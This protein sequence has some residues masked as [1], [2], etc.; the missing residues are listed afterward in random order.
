MEVFKEDY[1]LGN[2]LLPIKI[3]KTVLPGECCNIRPHWHDFMEI[4][5]FLEG[6]AVVQINREYY[7]VKTGQIVLL[8]ALDIHSV[9]GTAE[10][11]VLQF[12]PQLTADFYIDFIKAFPKSD[13]DKVLIQSNNNNRHIAM[14]ANHLQE[15]ADIYVEKL[16]GFEISIRGSIYKIISAIL[17]YSQEK[18]FGL[19]EYQGQ[20]QTLERLD[21]LLKYVDAHYHENITIHDAAR[22]LSFSPNYF[23]RFFKR[24]MGKTFLEYLNMFR[25]SKAEGLISTT[26]RSITDIA[27]SSG[28]SSVSYFNRI[29]KRYKGFCPSANRKLLDKIVQH[30]V[31]K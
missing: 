16:P 12:E 5:Y 1:H 9:S 25:C 28:F 20:K 19:S 21:V 8:N 15:I 10:Y 13:P 6:S 26:D 14:I 7:D 17:A 22:R 27:L 23:C 31:K 24:V 3:F 11:L 18:N 2:K 30:Q 29:Y 4:L